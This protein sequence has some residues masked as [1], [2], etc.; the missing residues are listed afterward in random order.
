MSLF[1]ISRHLL[2]IWPQIGWDYFPVKGCWRKSTF[3]G[4][5]VAARTKVIDSFFRAICCQ[6]ASADSS[7]FVS[8]HFY[9]IHSIFRLSWFLFIYLLSFF[10]NRTLLIYLYFWRSLFIIPFWIIFFCATSSQS[11]SVDSL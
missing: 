2:P 3:F 7:L 4:G 11:A 1:P 6:S 5:K 9:W 8:I 10:F